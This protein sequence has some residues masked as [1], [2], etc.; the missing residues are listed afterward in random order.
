MIE[1]RIFKFPDRRY[2]LLCPMGNEKKFQTSIYM[3][4]KMDIDDLIAKIR[5]LDSGEKKFET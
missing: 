1:I 5:Q 2:Q 4:D 3:S